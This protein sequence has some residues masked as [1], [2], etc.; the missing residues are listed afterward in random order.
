MYLHEDALK[1]LKKDL[2]VLRDQRDP[3][4]RRQKKTRAYGAPQSFGAASVSVHKKKSN[5]ILYY[6]F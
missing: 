1:T 4:V 3:C 2:R 6:R 5:Q